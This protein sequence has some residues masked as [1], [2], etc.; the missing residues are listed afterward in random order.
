[1]KKIKEIRKFHSITAE[2]LAKRLGVSVSMV[3]KVESGNRRASVTLAMKWAKAL[4][5]P[6]KEILD[7]FFK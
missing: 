1:M 2:K 4:K 6:E 3:H 7:Y 5:I